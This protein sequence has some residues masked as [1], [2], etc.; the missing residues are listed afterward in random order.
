MRIQ[1]LEAEQETDRI[2]D[3]V[4]R[5]MEQKFGRKELEEAKELERQMAR[6]SKLRG[7]TKSTPETPNA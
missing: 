3:R 2:M 6:N 1:F 4:E 7:V 5:E